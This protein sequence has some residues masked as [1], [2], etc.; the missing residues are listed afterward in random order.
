MYSMYIPPALDVAHGRI[1]Y[2]I[3]RFLSFRL[4]TISSAQS[5]WNDVCSFLVDSSIIPFRSTIECWTVEFKASLYLYIIV[6]AM[7]VNAHSFKANKFNHETGGKFDNFMKKRGLLRNCCGAFWH[8]KGVTGYS[9]QR[10]QSGPHSE[11]QLLKIIQSFPIKNE[12]T[13]IGAVVVWARVSHESFNNKQVAC[14]KENQANKESKTNKWNMNN[15][16][17]ATIKPSSADFL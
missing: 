9:D 3:I 17:H 4:I 6:Y 5:D 15:A 10:C 12:W 2:N 8:S 7:H 14:Q 13:S 16:L 1:W 11:S